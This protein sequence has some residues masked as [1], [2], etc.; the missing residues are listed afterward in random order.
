MEG[1]NLEAKTYRGGIVIR[2]SDGVT[3]EIMS[4][5]RR[6][7]AAQAKQDAWDLGVRVAMTMPVTYI[8]QTE[9]V[10]QTINTGGA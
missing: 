9:Y 10:V 5:H 4:P 7:T 2:R 8:V 1:D 3:V 6:E